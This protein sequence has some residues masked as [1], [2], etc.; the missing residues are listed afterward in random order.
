MT[1]NNVD[2]T[3]VHRHV[4]ALQ[5]QLAG[6]DALKLDGDKLLA[7]QRGEEA[8]ECYVAACKMSQDDCEYLAVF[9]TDTAMCLR[10]FEERA[11]EA[12]H[13]ATRATESNPKY[14]KAYLWR[15]VLHYDAGRW[16][17]S[18]ADFQHAK[19]LDPKLDGLDRWLKRGTHAAQ[20]EGTRKN[21]YK[22]LG[23]LCDCTQEEIRKTHW[24]VASGQR[25][26]RKSESLSEAYDTLSNPEKRSLYDFGVRHTQQSREAEPV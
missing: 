5:E 15:G 12:A 8:A 21:Y 4:I 19:E 11:E 26:P 14:A 24:Q 16:R 25:T 18:L 9:H 3:A 2:D 17:S 10:P 20:E 1:S 23:L 22:V 7:E 6:A 13:H